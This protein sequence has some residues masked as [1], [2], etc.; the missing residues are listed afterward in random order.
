MAFDDDSNG[1]IDYDEFLRQI[2]PEEYVKETVDSQ[3]LYSYGE[4]VQQA[5][6][7][8]PDT[9]PEFPEIILQ[10][11]ESK[12]RPSYGTASGM[13]SCQTNEVDNND[14]HQEQF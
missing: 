5:S 6:V 2:F 14:M 4:K 8:P 10:P 9:I 1:Y 13:A 3:I 7:M 11:A 12:F